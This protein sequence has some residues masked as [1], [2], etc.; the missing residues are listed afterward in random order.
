MDLHSKELLTTA[1]AAP[2]MVIHLVFSR[3][4]W[5]LEEV[6]IPLTMVK[7]SLMAREGREGVGR[8]RRRG[9]G[10]GLL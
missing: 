3:L 4:V 5:A 8:R 7:V 6:F 10:G 1:S 9:G 2:L